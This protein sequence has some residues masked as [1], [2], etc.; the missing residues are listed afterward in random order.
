MGGGQS[1]HL[2]VVPPGNPGRKGPGAK[3]GS[4]RLGGIVPPLPPPPPPPSPP[5]PPPSMLPSTPPPQAVSA[6]NRPP[7]CPWRV[8]GSINSSILDRGRARE[9]ATDAQVLSLHAL[10]SSLR[11]L[12]SRQACDSG[13]VR[14]RCAADH[15]RPRRDHRGMLIYSS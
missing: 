7:W 4:P 8:L 15:N 13:C 6:A 2:R 1:R 12:F 3:G 11:R 5:S 14:F 10:G 9:S